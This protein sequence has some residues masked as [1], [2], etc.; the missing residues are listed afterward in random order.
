[1]FSIV[2]ILSTIFEFGFSNSRVIFLNKFKHKY[3]KDYVISNIN[4]VLC[5]LLNIPNIGIAHENKVEFYIK[6][7]KMFTDIR[8][9]QMNQNITYKEIEYLINNFKYNEDF[10]YYE[11]YNSQKGIELF[12]KYLSDPMVLHNELW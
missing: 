3:Q 2:T 10:I 9:K 6:K 5:D 7:T 12:L 1:M 11:K 8:V 4:T